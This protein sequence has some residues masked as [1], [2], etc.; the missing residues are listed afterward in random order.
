MNSL[1]HDKLRWREAETIRN[2]LKKQNSLLGDSLEKLD[3]LI[4]LQKSINL[5]SLEEIFQSNGR[6]TP[7]YLICEVFHIFSF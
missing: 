7:I 5:L 2:I 6:K 4:Y 1:E 3:H